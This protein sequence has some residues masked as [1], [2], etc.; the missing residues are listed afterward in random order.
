MLSWLFGRHTSICS[1]LSLYEGEEVEC[2]CVCVCVSLCLLVCERARES[3]G[4]L[5][6]LYSRVCVCDPLCECLGELLAEEICVEL[7]LH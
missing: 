5:V 3:V 7:S 6:C 4:L 2:L 1:G